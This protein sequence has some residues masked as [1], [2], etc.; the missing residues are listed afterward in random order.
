MASAIESATIAPGIGG[1]GAYPQRR[2]SALAEQDLQP[3]TK[4]YVGNLFFEATEDDIRQHFEERPGSIKS[5]K[6]AFDH[7]GL[8]KG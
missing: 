6:L 4:V 5:V 1:P 3:S 8:S 7:R 2:S